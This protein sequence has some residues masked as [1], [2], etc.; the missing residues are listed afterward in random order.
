MKHNTFL[1][2]RFVLSGS[3]ATIANISFLFICVEFFSINPIMG[4]VISFIA[5]I[6]V[7][8]FLQ[9]IYT[10]KNKHYENIISQSGKFVSLSLFN[11]LF[12]T[13]LMFT[14]IELLALQYLLSQLITS[15]IIAVVSYVTYSNFIFKDYETRDNA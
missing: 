15:G 13:F 12:N 3:L 6:G 14:F 9:K 8:F 11:L 2:G 5:S 7:S 10:F 1:V 4:S